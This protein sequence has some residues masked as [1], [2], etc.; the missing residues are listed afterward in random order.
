MAKDNQDNGDFPN[1]LLKRLNPE[2]VEAVNAMDEE[3][4]KQRI[5]T[6]EGNL[7]E[8]TA[9]KKSDEKLNA[10]KEIVKDMSAPYNESKA[11]EQA[12]I[13]FCIFTLEGRGIN[14]N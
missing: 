13:Q 14:L 1:R 8:I 4:I 6:C 5:L 2:F 9:A 7:Y 11:Q 3:N 10:A 12:K